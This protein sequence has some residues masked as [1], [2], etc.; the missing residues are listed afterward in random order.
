[1]RREEFGRTEDG[2]D[3]IPPK[4]IPWR[5]FRSGGYVQVSEERLMTICSSEQ[6]AEI[7]RTDVR[8]TKHEIFKPVEVV[9]EIASETD[10][11]DDME[12]FTPNADGMIRLEEI[13]TDP[14]AGA[15]LTLAIGNGESVGECVGFS[16]KGKGIMAADELPGV[17]LF[18]S[19]MGS[20]SGYAK[21][22]DVT[23]ALGS[24]APDDADEQGG[25][26]MAQNGHLY[27]GQVF[28]DRDAFK[29]VGARESGPG[30]QWC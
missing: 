5:G 27:L 11:S 6:M 28:V 19:Q 12:M 14:P 13:P 15:N 25:E 29:E 7:R 24:N 26:E 9:D 18:S 20:S 16:S 30:M 8:L 23:A 21:R 1:M 2:T 4:P 3:V 22:Q 17:Q 10:S